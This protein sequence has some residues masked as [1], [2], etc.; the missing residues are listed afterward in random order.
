MVDPAGNVGRQLQQTLSI[1]A[2]ACQDESMTDPKLSV[3]LV[4]SSCWFSNVRSHVSITVWDQLRKSAYQKASYRCEI[5][6]GRGPKWPVECHEIWHYDDE[7]QV[8]RL[9]GMTALCPRCHEVKHL[10][11]TSIRG[12]AEIAEAHLAKVNDW[13]EKQTSDYLDSVWQIWHERSKYQWK[14]DLSYLDQ[15]GISVDTRRIQAA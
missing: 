13:T 10:G 12:R 3:E 7:K 5:C 8:Q 15:F 4:P 14:L 9:I 2:Y 11:L 6:G 1:P